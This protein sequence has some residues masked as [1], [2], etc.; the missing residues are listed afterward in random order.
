MRTSQLAGRDPAVAQQQVHG[1]HT[2]AVALGDRS[3]GLTSGDCVQCPA[4]VGVGDARVGA[5]LPAGC[6]CAR[7]EAGVGHPAAQGFAA[8]AG[9]GADVGYWV[10]SLIA[11]ER[12]GADARLRAR[13]AG[14][15]ANTG[16]VEPV[17]EGGGVDGGV[18][19]DVSNRVAGQ[20]ASQRAV[21]DVIGARRGAARRQVGLACPA[22]QRE[23]ADS[24]VCANVRYRVAGGIAGDRQSSL[25]MN[26]GCVAARREAGGSR[27]GEDCG[28][29]E[30][31][32]G[33]DRCLGF[34]GGEANNRVVAGGVR[35][36]PLDAQAVRPCGPRCGLSRR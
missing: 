25:R 36:G 14:A 7:G 17:V 1:G 27:P 18:R 35:R 2:D 28:R 9:L 19:D 16:V 3:D 8:D 23:G 6:A 33:G 31:Q 30:L 11:G 29:C 12:V 20:V 21:A 10:V 13:L 24:N 4:A 34:T 15:A 32:G 5:S 22:V 26:G